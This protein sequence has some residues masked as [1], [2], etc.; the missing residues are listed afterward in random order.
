VPGSSA[1]EIVGNYFELAEW[2]EELV[3][4]ARSNPIWIYRRSPP[5]PTPPSRIRVQLPPRGNHVRTAEREVDRTL[6]GLR[7]LGY[8]IQA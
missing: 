3:K 4:D 7:R 8:R 1:E 2:G 6:H 5:A